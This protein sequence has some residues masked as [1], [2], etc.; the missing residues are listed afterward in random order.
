MK[1]INYKPAPNLPSIPLKS[2][3]NNGI[4]TNKMGMPFRQANMTQ[5]SL[6]SLDRS[7]YIKTTKNQS[8]FGPKA[9]TVKTDNK[10]VITQR[11]GDASEYIKLKQINAVGGSTTKKGLAQNA[12]L[13]Y[14]NV[15]KQDVSSTLNRCRS[16]GCVVPKK[17]TAY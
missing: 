14:K 8:W 10:P 15:N 1:L 4:T 17:K 12:P 16:G 11:T 6:L 3:S 13:S 2:V 7:A 9:Y 5:G